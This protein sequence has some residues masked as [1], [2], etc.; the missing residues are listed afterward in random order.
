MCV[1]VYMCLFILGLWMST[2]NCSHLIFDKEAEI[3]TLE[4]GS[5]F[6]KW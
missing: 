1:F 3:H 4:K 5:I 2:H 6:N